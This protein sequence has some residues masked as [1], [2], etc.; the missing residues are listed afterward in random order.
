M[1]DRPD[2]D[3]TPPLRFTR[4]MGVTREEFL[5]TLPAAVA[6]LPWELDGD[7]VLIHH[8]AGSIRIT[9]FPRPPRRIAALRLPVLG[10]TFQFTVPS[11]ARRA[12][13]TRFDLAFHRGGG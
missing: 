6:P 9:L 8:P 4:E 7:R 5:R 3:G 1:S 13:M 10:V 12:F 2:P 11:A